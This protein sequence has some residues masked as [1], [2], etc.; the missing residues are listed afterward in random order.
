MYNTTTGP[1]TVRIRIIDH[2]T[3]NSSLKEVDLGQELEFRIK[4][5]PDNGKI[6]N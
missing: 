2:N 6:Y 5:T 3:G 4:V 1:P